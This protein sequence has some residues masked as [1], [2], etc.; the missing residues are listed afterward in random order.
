M[1]FFL[2]GSF[3]PIF[4]KNWIISKESNI[5]TPVFY[6]LKNL[7]HLLSNFLLSD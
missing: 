1:L 6:P 5:K 4:S 2:F 7:I 3:F